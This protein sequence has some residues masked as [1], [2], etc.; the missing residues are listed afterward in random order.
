MIQSDVITAKVMLPNEQ[1]IDHDK[2]MKLWSNVRYYMAREPAT[3]DFDETN[4]SFFKGHVICPGPKADPSVMPVALVNDL[5]VM[6]HSYGIRFVNFDATSDADRDTLLSPWAWL[7]DSEA[8]EYEAI[9]KGK[10][11]DKGSNRIAHKKPDIDNLLNLDDKPK[12]ANS[13]TAK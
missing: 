3:P 2:L 11:K 1:G 12:K 8:D 4:A 10:K 5:A 6:Q 13:K 7:E 9:R